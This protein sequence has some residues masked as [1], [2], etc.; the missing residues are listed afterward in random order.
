MNFWNKSDNCIT[1]YRDFEAHG[2]PTYV[3]TKKIKHR[4]CG[5]LGVQGLN[6]NRFTSVFTPDINENAGVMDF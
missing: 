6:F 1:I 3:Y 2:S 4:E 5:Q